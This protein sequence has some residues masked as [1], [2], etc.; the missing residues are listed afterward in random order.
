MKR[1]RINVG[2]VGLVFK[3]GDYQRMI[4]EGAHWLGLSESVKVYDRTQAF[5]PPV[6]I[7]ILLK[8]QALAD[9][10]IVVEVKDNELALKYENGNYKVVLPRGRYAFWKGVID[11]QFKSVDLSKIE[12]TEGIDKE[13]LSRAEIIPYIRVF[14]VLPYERGVLFVDGKFERVLESGTYFFWKN[15]TPI[16]VQKAD[17]RQ[18]Q[19]EVTGQEILTRDKAALRINFSTLYK[20]VDVEKALIDNRDYEKQLYTLVQLALREYVGTFMLDELLERKEGITEYVMGVLQAKTGKLGVKVNDCGVKDII[21]PGDVKDIMNRVLIAQ[22]Q[23]QANVITRREET[24]S[25]RSL[26]NTA[27]LMEDN[28]MLYKLKEMEFV[29]KVADKIGKITV[30][31]NGQVI[32]QLRSI[33]APGK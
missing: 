28:E 30:A 7:S 18:L 2:K 9:Q 13:T 4:C 32:D 25:T 29:E 16:S 33:F 14:E 11:Y 12:I 10:L 15:A 5:V 3:N 27:K 17:L 6:D 31:G 19:L 1:V 20:V 24:A 21:L 23:A 8:D 26:L 22:K